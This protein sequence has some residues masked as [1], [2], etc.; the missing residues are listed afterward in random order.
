MIFWIASYPKNGNTWLR[1]VLSAYYFTEDGNFTNDKI[2]KS[3]PQF[4]EKKYFANFS[5]DKSIPTSTSKFW[6]KAQEIINKEKKIKFFK[7]HNV[8]GSLN[9][10][11]FSNKY[12]SIGAVYIIRDPRNVITSIMNH[13][14]MKKE[15]ALNF[16][17]NEKKFTYDFF[18]KNDYS[19]FQFIS[20]WE[21]NYKSWIN[22]NDFPV[23]LIKYEDL[24][25]QT[26][27]VV[28]ELIN[29]I[30]KTCQLN[31]NF[32]KLK[33]QKAINSTSFEKLKKIEK[34]YGF[35]ESIK[36]KK[37]DNNKVPFF[38]LG[39]KNN[40]QKIFDSSFTDKL[41]EIFKESLQEL[42][43]H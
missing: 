18:K 10:N 13:F 16:M 26:F 27:N 41:N 35:S 20:S 9:N 17:I 2:L 36:S 39:P 14:E 23:K 5:Y 4:P 7:T 37:Q 29:F 31:F 25:N 28:K 38:H 15:E 6:I 32:N 42:H 11:E 40:W 1:S 22:N 33:A 34:N 19:D 43:Y 3:I 30:N 21:K 24:I 12:N 8:Y